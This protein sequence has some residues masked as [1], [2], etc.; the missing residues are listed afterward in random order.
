MYGADLTRLYG[1]LN[2]FNQCLEPVLFPQIIARSEGVGSIEANG[3]RQ[4]RAPIHKFSQV[5]EAVTDALALS[6]S[7]LQKYLQLSQ[8]Q[9]TR[10]NFQT[11]ATGANAIRLACTS[12]ASGMD[13]KVI[14]AKQYS[15]FKFLAE[16]LAR[17]LQHDGIG[18]REID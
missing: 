4:F 17:L 13:D 9:P 7:V 1:F 18:S 5:L 12:C 6:R 16:R 10:S 2:P 8:I 14:S 15:S 3:E 11:F